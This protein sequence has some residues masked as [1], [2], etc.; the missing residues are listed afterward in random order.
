MEFPNGAGCEAFTS[1]SYR[2]DAFRADGERGWIHFKQKAFTYRG[3]IVET[4]GGPL[5]F[6]PDVNQQAL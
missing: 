5:D 2:S 6:G 1:Y 4:S 3:A